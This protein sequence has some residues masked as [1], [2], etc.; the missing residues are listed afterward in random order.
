VKRRGMVSATAFSRVLKRWLASFETI[1]EAVSLL[2]TS[3]GLSPDTWRKRITA[4]SQ[5]SWIGRDLTSEQ[6][7]E[8]LTAADATYLWQEP[9]LARKR[10]PLVCEDCGKEI[11][12]PDDYRPLDLFRPQR[13]VSGKFVWDSTK[14][15][16]ARRPA[17]GPKKRAR[18]N[19]RRF[20]VYDLCRACAGEALRQRTISV[21]PDGKIRYGGTVMEDGKV[22]YLRTSERLAPKRGGRPRLLTDDELRAAYQIY[23]STTLSR[24]EIATKLWKAKGKGT[25]GGYESALL[26]GW[27]RLNLRLVRDVGTQIGMSV[28]G[29]DGT[30]SRKWKKRCK[31]RLKDGRR[32]GQY[33][34]IIREE[35]SSHPAEDG[36]CWNHW[37]HATKKEAA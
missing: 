10:K 25:K 1:E 33:V 26:Y 34:R 29:T 24:R 13:G 23:T 16:W 19:G 35:S 15:R 22:R 17:Q 37:N 12:D 30:K 36:L 28:H 5:N 21:K 11:T 18:R 31:A 2:S 9:P 14:Q 8:F 3:S 6:V 7:D 20:R 32:C 4:G 27:R